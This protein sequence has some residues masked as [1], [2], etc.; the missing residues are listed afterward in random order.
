MTLCLGVMCTSAFATPFGHLDSPTSGI[1]YAGA[2]N[3]T[4]WALDITG[5]SRV[6]ILVNNSFVGQGLLVTGVRPDIQ[7]QYPN[8]PQNNS[9][10]GL[11]VLTNQLP[12][13]GNG[14]YTFQAK[15][16]ATDGSSTLSNSI[17]VTIDNA[18]S[19]LPFGTIDTPTNGGTVSGT[20]Y[21]VW[22]WAISPTSSMN[23]LATRLVIT[24]VGDCY[25]N[26]LM[27]IPGSGSGVNRPDIASLFPGY[28]NTNSSGAYFTIDTT[29]L[30]NGLHSIS[31]NV[32]DNNG[33]AQGIGSKYFYVQN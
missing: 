7:T 14:Q 9:G 6:D 8:Y 11:Q 3:V 21:V 2:I 1:N 27:G 12:N 23:W 29:K 30:H 20:G 26:Y 19:L 31:V 17:T 33:N 5:I 16:Y 10:W 13:H 25:C 28:A 4:G 24:A 32:Y 22:L 15:F 18:H